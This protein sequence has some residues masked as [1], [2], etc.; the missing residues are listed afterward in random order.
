MKQDGEPGPC[1][2]LH[3]VAAD[4]SGVARQQCRDS[5]G[6]TDEAIADVAAKLAQATTCPLFSLPTHRLRSSARS[7]NCRSAHD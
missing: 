3:A 7:C 2:G 4:G 1:R 6:A 5:R